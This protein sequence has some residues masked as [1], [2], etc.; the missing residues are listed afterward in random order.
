MH[1]LEWWHYNTDAM[2]RLG[3][4]RS[5]LY[6]SRNCFTLCTLIVWSMA[7]NHLVHVFECV[8]VCMYVCM[9]VRTYVYK[10]VFVCVLVFM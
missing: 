5:V 1:V 3:K 6:K 9:Y 8:H 4:Y 2:H 7:I 10:C